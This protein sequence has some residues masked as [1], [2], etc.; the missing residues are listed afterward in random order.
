MKQ[1][2]LL[3]IL[4]GAIIGFLLGTFFY[5]CPTKL[6]FSGP[7]V[8]NEILLP[9]GMQEMLLALSAKYGGAI[10]L[11]I[12][13]FGGLASSIT[14]PRGH[15][16]KSISCLCFLVCTV[17]AFVQ[18]GHFL[19]EMSPGRIAITFFYIFVVLC[20]AIPLGGMI[21]FIERIRE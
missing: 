5:L 11:V 19:A 21:S 10:G 2:K 16:S 3:D 8:N 9:P 17:T 6:L 20:L 14:M 1:N 13:F 4:A 18:H 7:V 15:M 12:G